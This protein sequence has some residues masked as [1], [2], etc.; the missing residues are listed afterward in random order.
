MFKR[1]DPPTPTNASS[2]SKS[3]MT[4][5]DQPLSRGKKEVSLS[6]FSFL[7]SEIVQYHQGRINTY[8]ELEQK[9]AETGQNVGLRIYE[10]CVFRDKNSKREHKISTQLNF[11]TSV[12]WKTLYGKVADSLEK[13]EEQYMIYESMPLESRYISLGRNVTNLHCSYFTAGVI[14]GVLQ[15]ACFPATV[16]VAMTSNKEY[17][18]FVVSFDRSVIERELQINK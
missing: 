14:K 15:A 17:T 4:I 13:M 1:S 5:L 10:L 12:V 3:V 6:S 7:F 2:P 9:L 18:V 16:T 8:P 11:I